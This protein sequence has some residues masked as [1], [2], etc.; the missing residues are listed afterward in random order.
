M[1]KRPVTADKPQQQMALVLNIKEFIGKT[2]WLKGKPE[3]IGWYECCVEVPAESENPLP[4]RWWDGSQWSW[5]I[6]TNNT[7]EEAEQRKHLIAKDQERY[8]RGLKMPHPD[9][10]AWSLKPAHQLKR[11]ES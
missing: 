7:D 1:K 11:M 4:R 9:G 2:G 8:Y 10:Y 6:W 5:A 3:H